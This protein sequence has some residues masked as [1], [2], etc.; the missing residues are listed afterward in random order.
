LGWE[1]GISGR[2]E[3]AVKSQQRKH[4]AVDACVD[5]TSNRPTKTATCELRG[6][7]GVE[8]GEQQRLPSRSVVAR[9]CWWCCRR[10]GV[11]RFPDLI[12]AQC[13]S[14]CKTVKSIEGGA[15]PPN[16]WIPWLVDKAAAVLKNLR[17]YLAIRLLFFL[18]YSSLV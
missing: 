2:N 5:P 13:Q 16:P 6:K 7:A 17:N 10:A 1:L 8:V 15:R 9:G 14:K 11:A 4:V 3:L 12:Q 18:S